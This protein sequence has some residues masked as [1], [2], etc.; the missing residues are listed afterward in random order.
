[1]LNRNISRTDFLRLGGLTL[2]SLGGSS[3]LSV[4]QAKKADTPITRK[5]AFGVH[6]DNDQWGSTKATDAY[7]AMI[8]RAPR[9]VNVFQ[10]WRYSGSY[11]GF[12]NSG[13]NNL[14]AKYPSALIMLTWEPYGVTL[15]E[16]N[17]GNHDAYIDDVAADVIA[18]G[19][20]ILIRLGHEMNLSPSVGPW[21]SQPSAYKAMFR[22]VVDRF[23][24]KGA[25]N[26]EFVWCPNVIAPVYGG[27]FDQ[28]YPDADVVDWM[29]LDG[30]NWAASKSMPWYSF[31]Q[32][33]EQSLDH[34]ATINTSS[35]DVFICETGCHDVGGDKE[36]WL[37]D[38]R[39][40]LKKYRPEVRALVY[41]H[42]N[43][44]G[45]RWRVDY[46]KRAL[47]ACRRIAGDAHFQA[48]LPVLTE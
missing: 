40:Y 22:R 32:V 20:R 2:A 17:S 41:F 48:N 37:M 44:D 26:A 47:R 18:F 9:I 16:I 25:T 3:V 38:M 28:Y 13:F 12:S 33:F 6:A 42:K 39:K 43:A 15:S 10:Y 19:R 46:P 34:M 14:Q 45:A 8:G 4:A 23:R 5:L 29:G 35:K 21:M 31:R 24:A 36:A 27:S 30:Y 7:T 11:V 1:M